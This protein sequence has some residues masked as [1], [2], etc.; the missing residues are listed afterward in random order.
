MHLEVLEPC[1]KSFKKQFKT[2]TL[3]SVMQVPW[4]LWVQNT[5]PKKCPYGP[6]CNILLI[7]VDTRICFFL[8]PTPWMK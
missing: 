5:G 4:Y 6:S 7:K 8:L 3:V 1:R 2:I